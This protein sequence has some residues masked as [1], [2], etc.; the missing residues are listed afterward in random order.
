MDDM[1]PR[2]RARLAELAATL[3]DALPAAELE[4]RKAWVAAHGDDSL[5]LQRDG[6]EVVLSW[7]GKPLVKIDEA[8]LR[9]MSLDYEVE[10]RIAP[11]VDVP[12]DLSGSA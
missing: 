11:P 7:G 12:D 3:R 8:G 9:A 4:Q 10:V 2:L 1:D 6:S 5:R